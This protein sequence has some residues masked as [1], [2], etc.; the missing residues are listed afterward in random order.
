M[1][2]FVLLVIGVIAFS[3]LSALYFLVVDKG[4]STRTVKA[5]TVRVALSIALFLFLVLGSH[6]GL[7]P[8]RL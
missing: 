3:L 4:N 8:S 2:L 6:F 7:I 5:L 1:R